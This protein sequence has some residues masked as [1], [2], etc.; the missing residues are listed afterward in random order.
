MTILKQREVWRGPR[1]QQTFALTTEEGAHV[2]RALRAIKDQLGGWRRLAKRLDC[3]VETVKK[4]GALDSIHH[5]AHPSPGLALRAAQLVGVP[6]E[7]LLS[8]AWPPPEE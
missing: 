1:K 5:Q 7:D 8:G 4:A 6:V 3:D 2:K